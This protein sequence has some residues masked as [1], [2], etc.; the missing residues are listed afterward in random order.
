MLPL[1]DTFFNKRFFI[2]N[3]VTDAVTLIRGIG[4]VGELKALIGKAVFAQRPRFN[5]HIHLPPNFSAFDN[6]A[7]AVLLADE[8][9]V[10]IV[11]LS[12]YYDY[13]VYNEFTALAA[14]HG[15]FP[16]FGLEVI[17]LVDELVAAGVKINDPGNPGRMYICGKGITKFASPSSRAAELLAAIR[18]RDEARMAEMTAKVA[19]LFA[20]ASV[21]TKLTA[22]DIITRVMKR[23]CVE[24]ERI[25]LQERHVAQGFQE[26]FF[27]MIPDAGKRRKFMQKLF[28]AE[29]KS[30]TDAV[31]VQGEI[32][33]H[34]MKAGKP[35]FV[36]ETFLKF[37]QAHELIL[38]LG[39]I[40][41]Y[42]TLADGVN[43]I[44]EYEN[45]AG[46]LV[47]NLRSNG[48]HMAELIPIR[49]T[50]EVLTKYVKTLRAAGIVVVGGTEHNTLDL[51]GLEPT[52]IGKAAVPEDIKDIFFEGACV[53]AG[54]QFLTA[55]GEV[56]FVD[57][58]GTPNTQYDSPEER[59]EA[60][61]KLG[62]T[63]IDRYFEVNT[64]KEQL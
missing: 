15:I 9:N 58:N 56:G 1:G 44:C 13:S 57:V 17:S 41:C 39:G 46:K 49:N 19:E 40:P 31:G 60:M 55:H 6:V 54:H 51:I 32:R 4:S 24:R 34:L 35:A 27:E 38:A 37:P 21:D 22:P 43:P 33:S 5:S 2:M 28:G 45:P 3:N 36:T 30:A 61:A 50:P 7:Q 53:A 16:I 14:P 52:C 47:E 26:V 29:S 62:A 8:Q 63:V 59:I 10:R 20:A 12:N 42:P 64:K 18:S 48:L 25:T 23:H 11:G